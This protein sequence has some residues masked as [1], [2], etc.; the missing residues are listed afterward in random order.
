M[1][2]KNTG[3]YI[4]LIDRNEDL[5]NMFEG[6]LEEEYEVETFTGIEAGDEFVDYMKS[7]LAPEVLFLEGFASK[8]AKTDL[9]AYLHR[10][11][12]ET[13]VI[14]VVSDRDYYEELIENVEDDLEILVERED[15]L[16]K[17]DNFYEEAK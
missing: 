13:D 8:S 2:T 16:D 14:G 11:A 10:L 15:L 1:R 12:P 6:W 3:D 9:P 17:A 4:A 5:A 7:G